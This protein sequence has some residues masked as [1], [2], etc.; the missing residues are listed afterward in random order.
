MI[1]LADTSVDDFNRRREARDAMWLALVP[2]GVAL[3]LGVLLLPRSAPPESVPLPIADAHALERIAA[4]ADHQLAELAR[5][6]P[7]P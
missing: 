3:V 7:L 2:L 4:D 1:P 5:H 6:E